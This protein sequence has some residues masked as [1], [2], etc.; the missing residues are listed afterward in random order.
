MGTIK[1]THSPEGI[2][3]VT[4][5]NP[6]RFN[7]MQLSMWQALAQTMQD[8][9]NDH[10]TRVVIIRGEGEKA[11]VSGADITEFATL[12]VTPEDVTA[13]DEAV[14][15]AENAISACKK[16]VIAA[17]SGICF[18]GG[19]GIALCCDLRFGS[20]TARFCLPAAKLGL[21]YGLSNIKRMQYVLGLAHTY[22]L[23]LTARVYPSADA[24]KIGMIHAC[25]TDVFAHAKLQADKIAQL[26]PLTLASIKLTMCHLYGDTHAPD[27]QAVHQAVIDC[28]ESSDYAEGRKAFTEKRT[29]KFLGR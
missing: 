28:F 9:S 22:E 20:D 6:E 10:S 13:Y 14:L 4:L 19:L 5:S 3:T 8:L 21:G 15:N 18:G 11:F 27:A 1:T 16:P 26:A 29:P 7:A 12:R 2:A 24:L 17:I 23:L 25:E